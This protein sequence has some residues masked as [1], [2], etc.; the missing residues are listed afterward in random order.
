MSPRAAIPLSAERHE[1]NAADLIRR[2]ALRTGW[3]PSLPIPV[4]AIAERELDLRIICE[5]IPEQPGEWILGALVPSLRTVRLNENHLDLFEARS[6][7]YEFTIAH[8]IGHWVYDADDPDQTSLLEPAR[9]PLLC[10]DLGPSRL[11]DAAKIREINANKFAARLLLPA[12]LV[13]AEL[14]SDDDLSARVDSLAT[15]WKVSKRTLGIRFDELGL[16]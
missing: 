5:P 6:G 8:E 9:E 11:T 2:Y 7:P 14:P 12:D 16:V 13:L 3:N 15:K 1:A 4:E 10:R